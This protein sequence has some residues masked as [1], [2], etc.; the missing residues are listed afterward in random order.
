[1]EPRTALNEPSLDGA[2]FGYISG[3]HHLPRRLGEKIDI[4]S[5]SMFKDVRIKTMHNLGRKQ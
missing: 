1:M 4:E 3:S 2:T 5:E